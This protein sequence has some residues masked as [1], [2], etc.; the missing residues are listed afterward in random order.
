[1]NAAQPRISEVHLHIAAEPAAIRYRAFM[2]YSHRGTARAKWLHKALESYRIDK[3]LVGRETAVG[4]VPRTL[5]PIFRDREDF[6]WRAHT[7]RR[8]G[9][10]SRVGWPLHHANTVT[11]SIF[12]LSG[13]W[14]KRTL[15]LRRIRSQAASRASSFELKARVTASLFNRGS[16]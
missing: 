15:H 7:D 2:S 16:K 9:G 4:P 11:A 3:D 10:R 14:T 8:Y 13:P 6:L 1:M 5:R 12:S